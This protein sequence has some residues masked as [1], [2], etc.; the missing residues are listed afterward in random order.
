M[1]RKI[2]KKPS[3]ID[4]WT[5]KS[6]W[7]KSQPSFNDTCN[8]LSFYNV[9]DPLHGNK[10]TNFIDHRTKNLVYCDTGKSVS[11]DIGSLDY[12]NDN[13]LGCKEIDEE[14]QKYGEHELRF[15]FAGLMSINKDDKVYVIKTRQYQDLLLG[16]NT[17]FKFDH[18]C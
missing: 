15:S 16:S 8:F 7:C 17:K 2:R 9:D 10:L 11:S 5:V 3:V 6:L 4:K 12:E 13:R 14:I 1:G 18:D